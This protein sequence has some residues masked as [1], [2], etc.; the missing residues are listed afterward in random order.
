[1]SRRQ[2]GKKKRIGLSCR[3][4]EKIDFFVAFPS[5]GGSAGTLPPF[6]VFSGRRIFLPDERLGGSP[7]IT[8]ERFS[9]SLSCSYLEVTLNVIGSDAGAT[10]S[11]NLF[12]KARDIDGPLSCAF[13][14]IFHSSPRPIS[15]RTNFARR[16]DDC[17]PPYGI[18]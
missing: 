4:N 2:K 15:S 3:T 14:F 12:R 8:V 13:F 10:T 7:P 5:T 11:C 1:M 6:P 9:P 17:N 18:P 16:R